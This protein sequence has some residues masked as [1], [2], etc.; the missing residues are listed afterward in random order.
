MAGEEFAPDCA[1]RHLVVTLY[2]LVTEELELPYFR[3]GMASFALADVNRRK[4]VPACWR[5]SSKVSLVANRA[6]P[7][8]FAPTGGSS[9][10][11][12]RTCSPVPMVLEKN[13][14]FRPNMS[15][16]I[17]NTLKRES[18]VRILLRP[19]ASQLYSDSLPRLS[20]FA[21]KSR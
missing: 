10:E 1:H 5:I 8:G 3:P 2:P 21:G 9:E 13:A 15:G 16:W 19:P 18:R 11:A 7:F 17:A 4:S 20:V 6:V 14:Y 12:K